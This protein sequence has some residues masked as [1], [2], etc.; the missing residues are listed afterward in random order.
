MYFNRAGTECCAV[1]DSGD[2]LLVGTISIDTESHLPVCVFSGE[3]LGQTGITQTAT[4]SGMTTPQSEATEDWHNTSLYWGYELLTGATY[5]AGEGGEGIVQLYDVGNFGCNFVDTGDYES[6][7]RAVWEAANIDP[8]YDMPPLLSDDTTWIYSDVWQRTIVYANAPGDEQ[9]ITIGIIRYYQ[10]S[11]TTYSWFNWGS[12]LEYS[13][14]LAV[15]ADYRIDSGSGNDERL[16]GAITPSGGETIVY[17][18]DTTT[19]TTDMPDWISYPPNEVVDSWNCTEGWI[20]EEATDNVRICLDTNTGLIALVA[21]PL[22]VPIRKMTLSANCSSTS[23]LDLHWTTI[24]YVD[25]R[26]GVAYIDSERR[27]MVNSQG[28]YLLVDETEITLTSRTAPYGAFGG[29][30]GPHLPASVGTSTVPY[31]IPGWQNTPVG[32]GL[33]AID[34]HGNILLS[35]W[36]QYSS[37]WGGDEVYIDALVDGLD[38]IDPLTLLADLGY[39]RGSTEQSTLYGIAYLG[40]QSAA[41]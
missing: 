36:Y 20:G 34:V 35:D 33:I 30:N 6:W 18:Y 24:V 31:S 8:A 29:Y 1:T 25:L 10:T 13:G 14:S 39:S 7:A 41:S 23:G 37:Y 11:K 22:S 12:T 15:C 2:S 16:I 5:Q 4:Y 21:G 17:E 9:G 27:Q 3:E 40:E 38:V 32:Q 19:I 28:R 26:Y